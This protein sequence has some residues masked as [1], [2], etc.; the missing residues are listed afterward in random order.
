M[1]GPSPTD[2]ERARVRAFEVIQ[3]LQAGDERALAEL[4]LITSTA[5]AHGWDRVVRVGLYGRAVAAWV[6]NSSSLAGHVDALVDAGRDAGDPVVTALGLAMRAAFVVDGGPAASP[7]FD[8]DLAEAVVLLEDAQSEA[9]AGSALELISA[10]TGCGIAFGYRFL[11][12]LGDGHYEAALALAPLAEPGIGDTL[13]AAVMFNRA[14]EHVSW[15][16]RL[17]EIGDAEGL[18]ERWQAWAEVFDRAATFD[19]PPAWDAERR[20]LGLLMAAIAGRDV[21]GE[22]ERLLWQTSTGDRPDSRAAGHLELARALSLRRRPRETAPGRRLAA[23]RALRAVNPDAFPLLYDLALYLAAEEEATAGQ[24][25]GLQCAQ[26]QISHRWGDRLSQLSAMQTRIAARRLRH[27]LERVS[28]EVSRDDLTGI[29]NRRALVAFTAD[30]D[31]RHVERVALI[32]LDIDHFKEVNDRHGHDVGDAVLSRLATILHTAVR[33]A[34]LAV[35]LGGDEFV[36]VLPGAEAE[37]A[38][39]RAEQILDQVERHPWEEISPGLRVSVSLGVAAGDRVD[40]D[41]IRGRADR[42]VYDSKRAGG[43]RFSLPPLLPGQPQ[44]GQPQSG[45]PHSGQTHSGQLHSG[46]LRPRQPASE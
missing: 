42:S 33:P 26:R 38:A 7:A 6:A 31:R 12:E 13:L 10:H 5:E 46:Q 32:M 27:E 16:S 17:R 19:M 22:A 3:E 9:A 30:L 23:V 41:V 36:V 15:A 8:E 24:P 44:S 43:R 34:D 39:E 21:A 11:W 1:T 25:Y 28:H 35:R 45:Q 20:T 18:A 4:Q 14:E 29:G 40:L 2:E 37:T